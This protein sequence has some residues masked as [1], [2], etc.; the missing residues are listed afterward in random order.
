ML[1]WERLAQLNVITIDIFYE[2]RQKLKKLPRVEIKELDFKTVIN[3]MVVGMQNVSQ[4]LLPE[5]FKT[6]GK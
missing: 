4:L 6:K 1:L 5:S 2:K 3:E